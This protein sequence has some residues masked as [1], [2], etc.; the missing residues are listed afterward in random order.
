MPPQVIICGHSLGGALATLCAHHLD[1]VTHVQ[2]VLLHVQL[3]AGGE[4]GVRPRLQGRDGQADAKVD[5]EL[6][7]G[8]YFKAFAFQRT[9]DPASRKG[10][11]GAA[12]DVPV[13]K[14]D[15]QWSTGWN[16]NTGAIL[17][18]L[19]QSDEIDFAEGSETEIF[20]HI[21]N[22][23]EMLEWRTILLHPLLQQDG[24][25]AAR[26]V[27]VRPPVA[28]A[29]PRTGT[30]EETEHGLAFDGFDLSCRSEE[31]RVADGDRCR[32]IRPGLPC[33]H[34]DLLFRCG[35]HEESQHR[36]QDGYP[37]HHPADSQPQSCGP[38]AQVQPECEHGEGGVGDRP[39]LG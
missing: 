21:Q 12:I 28:A 25:G 39:G 24:G 19:R 29:G 6:G 18:L 9:Y 31:V 1:T 8:S 30:V 34:H 13:E 14:A 16:T 22:R 35:P 36:G 3:P 26:D 23:V 5:S 37:G 7:A 2:A 32:S 17:G 33:D 10:K 20:Y 38:E 11:H 15:I 27:R 4:P